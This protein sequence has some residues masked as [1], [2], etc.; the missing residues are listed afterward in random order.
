MLGSDRSETGGG[1][2]YGVES[3]DL[4]VALVFA[5]LD[6]LTLPPATPF[7]GLLLRAW[8]RFLLPWR[9]EVLRP[10]YALGA[11]T[12]IRIWHAE[13]I[14]SS[15]MVFSVSKALMMLSSR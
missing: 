12:S 2:V 13:F 5:F 15:Q 3:R 10:E 7:F 8:P 9:F 1:E 14:T 11:L 6:L 4:A